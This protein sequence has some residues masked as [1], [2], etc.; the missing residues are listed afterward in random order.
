VRRHRW[1]IDDATCRRAIMQGNTAWAQ[2][3]SPE[4]DSRCATTAVE[5]DERPQGPITPALLT[6]RS[7][8]QQAFDVGDGATM[9]ASYWRRR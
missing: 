9:A 6:S 4:I 1:E 3:T 8:G 5:L 7:M 2:I